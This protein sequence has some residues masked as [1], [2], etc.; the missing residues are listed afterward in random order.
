MKNFKNQNKRSWNYLSEEMRH[1]CNNVR[2]GL[3]LGYNIWCGKRCKNHMV[4]FSFDKQAIIHNFY[5][6]T[7][8]GGR[9]HYCS[10]CKQLTLYYGNDD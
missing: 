9:F 10:A 5:S 2:M 3:T 4:Q 7:Q 6:I 1:R 8:N